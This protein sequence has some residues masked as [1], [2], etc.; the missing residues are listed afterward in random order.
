MLTGAWRFYFL[1]MSF[2]YDY[3]A[4]PPIDYP[5]LLISDTQE[6]QPDGTTRAYVF[7]DSEIQ[8][9]TTIETSVWQSSQYYSGTGGLTILPN[10]SVVPWRRIAATLLD[11][12]AANAARLSSVT[13]LLDVKLS[14]KEAALALRT[15]AQALRDADDNSG[16]FAIIEQVNNQ[17][18]FRDRFWK[19]IQRQW[20]GV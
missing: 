10:Q 19:S 4:N 14:P 1:T 13:Q 17:F 3:G 9:A 6:F 7:E 15:Q 12:L 8:A 18:S 16:S 20:G 2:S 5:R 11:S